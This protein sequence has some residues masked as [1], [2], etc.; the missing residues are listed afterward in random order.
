MP[1]III[2]L[3]QISTFILKR[4]VKIKI[5]F[6]FLFKIKTWPWPY[7]GLSADI[8]KQRKTKTNTISDQSLKVGVWNQYLQVATILVTFVKKTICPGYCPYSDDTVI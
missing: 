6:T 1:F 3:F 2:V 7:L 8:E 4:S 5:F